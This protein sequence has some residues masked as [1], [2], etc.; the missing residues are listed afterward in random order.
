MTK[1]NKIAVLGSGTMG[2]SIAL[3]AAW[4]GI[5]VKML[6][7][8]AADIERGRSGIEDK[9]TVLHDNGLITAEQRADI[10]TRIQSTTSLEEAI[11]DV[12]FI[13]EAI[14]E[15]L[16]MKQE[17]FEKLDRLTPPDVILGSN[18][19]GL[20][21]TRIAERTDN[22]ARTVVTHFWNPAH[23]LPLVEVVRGEH[24][25]NQTVAIAID[26]LTAMKK[27]PI[28]VKKDVPG[29]V[30]NRL[31][32]ALFREAQHILEE[33]VASKE[34]IDAAVMYSLGRRLPVTG[35]FMT[36]DMG[37]L[38]VFGTISN[39]LFADLSDAKTSLP[40]MQMLMDEGKYGQK[41]G[42]GFYEWDADFSRKMN[43]LRENELI[44]WMKKDL[45]LE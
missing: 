16:E 27:K 13:I 4:F 15:I 30:G 22:P 34:D 9:L 21:P 14:P 18:T 29:S 38:D 3:N 28:E 11:A 24:T 23:L 7:V 26:L 43:Q 20:S 39:Y 1:I 5:E 31:Q 17:L 8:D 6:G 45:G 12:P 2:H 35:P 41:T 25:S 10:P 19:S 32:Y 37:G 33:G 36:A 44:R 40:T 42:S